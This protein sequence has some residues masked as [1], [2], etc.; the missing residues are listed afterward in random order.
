[1]RHLTTTHPKLDALLQNDRAILREFLSNAQQR[2]AEKMA[3][4]FPLGT[5]GQGWDRI[6]KAKAQI[7]EEVKKEFNVDL[8]DE[9]YQELQRQVERDDISDE[10]FDH[11]R[12]L[13]LI[14]DICHLSFDYGCDWR[15]ERLYKANR[16]SFKW[17]KYF[18]KKDGKYYSKSGMFGQTLGEV[19]TY[20]KDGELVAEKVAGGWWNVTRLGT[21]FS[22]PDSL[23]DIVRD[24]EVDLERAKSIAKD[25]IKT[26][27]E[28][29]HFSCLKEMRGLS[30]EERCVLLMEVESEGVKQALYSFKDDSNRLEKVE[31]A[32]SY[33]TARGYLIAPT[34][35]QIAQQRLKMHQE[36][37][38]AFSRQSYFQ[39]QLAK[40]NE[41]HNKAKKALE[42]NLKVLEELMGNKAQIIDR[43]ESGEIVYK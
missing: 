38:K 3:D 13:N 37:K 31:A 27:I 15:Y 4:K 18:T 17:S 36:T 12:K 16:K 20:L 11:Q 33:L 23:V 21:H 6:Q 30:S 5:E 10:G 2:V 9:E 34:T 35:Y 26:Q 41:E 32:A 40:I 29:D 19:Y 24:Y 8:H 39:N 14:S 1:M 22:S 42:D 43:I 25:D 7:I 28:R